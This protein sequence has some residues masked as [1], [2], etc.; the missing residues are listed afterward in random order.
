MGRPTDYNDKILEEARKYIASC[1]DGPG[2]IPGKVCVKLPTIEGMALFLKINRDTLYEWCK[3]HDDF[4]DIIEDL[5]AEQANRLINMGLSGDYSSTIAKVLLSKHG[6]REG[7]ESMGANGSP[8]IPDKA[9][10]EMAAAAVTSFLTKKPHD[11]PGD[12]S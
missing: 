8:L 5:R 4:S 11:D 10:K 2:A 6:Y 1:E 9:D 3:I 12:I 7:I